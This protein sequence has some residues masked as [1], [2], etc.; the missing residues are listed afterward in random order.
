MIAKLTCMGESTDAIKQC[1][2][3]A[4]AP[5]SNFAGE[6]RDSENVASAL[7]L[8]KVYILATYKAENTTRTCTFDAP[9][10]RKKIPSGNHYRLFVFYFIFGG[11]FPPIGLSAAYDRH[12]STN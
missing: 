11:L 8:A 6:I 10:P 5:P 12:M 4:R 1:F 7:R 2:A 3:R 9:R